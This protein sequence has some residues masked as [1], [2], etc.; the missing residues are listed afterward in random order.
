MN[1]KVGPVPEKKAGGVR[2]E[3]RG[4]RKEKP[5]C[6]HM[7]KSLDDEVARWQAPVA[8]AGEVNLS[9]RLGMLDTGRPMER[10]CPGLAIVPLAE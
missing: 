3:R 5:S 2:R 8:R 7:R 9:D 10:S 4:A 1:A 6:G